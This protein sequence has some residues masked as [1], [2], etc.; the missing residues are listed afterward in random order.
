LTF[1]GILPSSIPTYRNLIP[2]AASDYKKMLM[3]VQRVEGED[4]IHMLKMMRNG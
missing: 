1:I 4:R 3:I 2:M